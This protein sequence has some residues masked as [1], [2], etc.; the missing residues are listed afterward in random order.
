M[1]CDN[2]IIFY[3]LNLFSYSKYIINELHL[4][5]CKWVIYNGKFYNKCIRF[6]IPNKLHNSQTDR[7]CYG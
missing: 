4:N 2:K 3:L 1:L 7:S 5:A 6:L